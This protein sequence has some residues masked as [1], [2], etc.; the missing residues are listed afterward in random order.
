MEFEKREISRAVEEINECLT[1]ILNADSDNYIFRLKQFF[2][3]LDKNQVLNC[4][5]KPYVTMELDDSKIGFIKSNGMRSTFVIPEDDDEEISLIL[6]VLNNM[7]DNDSSVISV[8]H[9]IYMKTSI[10]DNLYLF[11]TNII[12]PAFVKLERKLR[13]KI[14]DVNRY[15]EDKIDSSKITIINV[16]SISANNSMIAVGVDINQKNTGDVFSE[17]EKVIENSIKDEELKK[18][19]FILLQE[20]NTHKNKVSF[21][22]KYNQFITKLGTYVTIISPFLPQLVAFFGK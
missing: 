16:G 19:L 10:N 2:L 21:I 20:M 7:K 5:V 13:Y 15:P 12:Q 11:N 1:N 18:E 6:K 3:K 4:I 8:P 17:I 22:E 14:E 9:T